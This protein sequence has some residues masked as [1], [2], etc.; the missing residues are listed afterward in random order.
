MDRKER[1][2][3][4]TYEQDGQQHSGNSV[5]SEYDELLT[6]Y[7]KKERL[8]RLTGPAVSIAVHVVILMLAALLIVPQQKDRRK[9]DISAEDMK[10]KQLKKVK[11][12]IKRWQK[13]TKIPVPTIDPP[14]VSRDAESEDVPKKDGF[15]KPKAGLDD[16]ITTPDVGTVGVSSGPGPG[17]GWGPRED[18]EKRR[19]ALDSWHAPPKSEKAVLAALRWL[20]RTQKA[21]GSWGQYQGREAK[22]PAAVTGLALL[23]YLAHGEKPVESEEFGRTVKK[24]T[25]WS[26]QWRMKHGVGKGYTSAINTYALCEAYHMLKLPFLERAAAKGVRLIVEGQQPRGAWNYHYKKGDRWDLSVTGWQIQALIAGLAADIDVQGLEV[27]LLDS[28]DFLK[29]VAYKGGR[30]GYKSPGKGSWGM[31]G[32]GVL[33]LQLLGER[34]SREAEVAAQVIGNNLPF[35]WEK[36]EGEE[37]KTSPGRFPVYAWYY[38]TQAMFHAGKDKFYK[39]NDVYAPTIIEM[40]REAGYW[41]TPASGHGRGPWYTTTLLTLSLEVYYRYLRTYE[42]P[43]KLAQKPEQKGAETGPES[44][45][46]SDI[47]L[48]AGS[49]DIIVN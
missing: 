13:K 2:E 1:G 23:A 48:P 3:F 7:E 19:K 25:Q 27:A 28:I 11:K 36:T 4:S 22:H 41:E 32:A 6:E 29:N 14:D 5:F 31:E 24:A 8:R 9:T 47:G 26:A 42:L 35:G 16:G 17:P 20:K 33:C 45:S 40:Q 30:F 21:D 34:Q 49:G 12:E 46:G 15:E 44:S 10:V 18:P 38:L 39:W 37:V 43:R